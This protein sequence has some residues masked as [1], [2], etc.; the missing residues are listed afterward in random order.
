MG[1]LFYLL[2]IHSYQ[3]GIRIAALWNSKA[4][5]WVA[6][7]RQFPQLNQQGNKTIWMHCASL[8]EFEQ[9]RPLLEAIK[10]Q[11][12]EVSIVLTFFSPSGY[13]VMKNYKGADHIFYLPMDSPSNAD[14]MIETIQPSL[15][16]WVKY[17][18]WYYYLTAFKKNNIPVLMVSGI[19]R[20]EQSFFKWYG[21]I[22]R[23]MLQSF[24]WFFLQNNDSKELLET[25]GIKNNISINGDTR[26]DRVLEIAAKFEPMLLIEKFCGNSKVIVAGS[27][28]EEDEEE[29]VHYVRSN[30]QIKFIIAPHEIDEGNIKDVQKEFAGSLLYSELITSGQSP[31]TEHSSLAAN[32]LIIDNIGMLSRLY[33]YA[34]ITFVGG[35]FEESGIHNVLEPAVH[36]KPVIYGPEYEK[37][38]EAVDLVECGAGICIENALE[39]EKVLTELWND[40]ALL[41]QKSEAA[42]NYVY[43]KAGATKKIMEYIQE[44]RLLTS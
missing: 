16:L 31:I 15:V 25:V 27:T 5:L 43:S 30:P 12:P 9:G 10:K 11:Y 34:H 39:L 28:W 20:E 44:K 3:L 18:F 14:R 21:A 7:R 17:E 35:G 23:E 29:L 36:G 22:W 6:G 41:K 13:E 8:G 24:N 26:F 2:F 42:K 4:K 33:H 1:K 40:E 38:A 32:V 37:F 19:F